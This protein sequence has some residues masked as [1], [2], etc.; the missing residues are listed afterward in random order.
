MAI[1]TNQLD[2]PQQI[3]GVNISSLALFIGSI[4]LGALVIGFLA[5]GALLIG[6]WQ[7]KRAIA[8]RPPFTLPKFIY[9]QL[10][11][12]SKLSGEQF[13]AMVESFKTEWCK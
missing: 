12:R 1:L 5:A 2:A 4:L 9:K 11:T 10:P 7:L 3:L 6:V 13:N 8:K